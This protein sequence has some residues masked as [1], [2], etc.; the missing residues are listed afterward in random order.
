MMDARIT[1]TIEG[2]ARARFFSG[3]PV[4]TTRV[5]LSDGRVLVWDCV[6]R[7]YTTCH[8]LS[9]RAEQRI[10]AELRAQSDT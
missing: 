8:S 10:A 6:A 2:R 9:R 3:Y 5:R 1:E 4:E 7:H